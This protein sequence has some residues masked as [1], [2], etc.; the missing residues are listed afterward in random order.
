VLKEYL[1]RRSATAWQPTLEIKEIKSDIRAYT[2]SDFRVNGYTG[3][4]KCP[5]PFVA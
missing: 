2:E 4:G 1:E 5:L 3:G